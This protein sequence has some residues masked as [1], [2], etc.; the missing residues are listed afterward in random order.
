MKDIWVVKVLKTNEFKGIYAAEKKSVLCVQ[1]WEYFYAIKRIKEEI[2]AIPYVTSAMEYDDEA[3]EE[4]EEM[5]IFGRFVKK[6]SWLNFRYQTQIII[7]DIIKRPE[8]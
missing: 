4:T 3:Q 8:D 7:S 5:F 1:D 6:G 2:K